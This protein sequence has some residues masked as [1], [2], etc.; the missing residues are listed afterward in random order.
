MIRWLAYPLVAALI[1]VLTLTLLLL[2]WPGPCEDFLAHGIEC[3]LTHGYVARYKA[4][5]TEFWC[6]CPPEAP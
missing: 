5:R 1:F 3:P 6:E 4:D 2:P